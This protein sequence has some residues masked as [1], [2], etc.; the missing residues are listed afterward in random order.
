LYEQKEKN[1]P[2]NIN[3]KNKV[4]FR[5]GVIPAC[6]KPELIENFKLTFRGLKN[7]GK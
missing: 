6:P 1:P 4:I 2:K 3:K 7:P 5:G